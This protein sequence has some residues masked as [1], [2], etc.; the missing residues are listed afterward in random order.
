MRLK[1]LELQGY[2]SFAAKTEFLFF[3]GITAIVG[4]NGSGKSNIADAVRW[5]LG[6]QSYRLLRGKRTED[7][8][9]SGSAQR[10]RAG[11]AQVTMTLDNSSGW[12]PLEYSEISITR[13]AYRSGENE[14]L[15]NGNRVRLRDV[16]ELLGRSGLARRSYTVIGQGLID[17]ALALRPEE[18]RILFEEAAGITIHQM[19]RAEALSKLEATQENL[20]RVK[21]ILSE[22]TPRLQVLQ[23]QAERAEQYATLQDRLRQ[24]LRVWYGHQ[25]FLAE[26]ALHQAQEALRRQAELRDA[27]QQA[28]Q[29]IEEQMD[30]LRQEQ[31]ALREQLGQRHGESARL[32]AE[33]EAL[34]RELAV[35][36][37]RRR[38]M[39][40][41]REALLQ[42]I[43]TLRASA[44]EHQERIAGA[45]E[46]LQALEQE[47]Q[48]QLA[49]AAE[50]EQKVQA[51]QQERQ[52]LGAALSA[53]RDE[54]FQVATR[55]A[56]CRNRMT[57]LDERRQE[58]Q[59]EQRRHQE[60]IAACQEEIG[61]RERELRALRQ[62]LETW[63]EATAVLQNQRQSALEKAEEVRRQRPSIEKRLDEARGQLTRLRARRD[64][65]ARTREEMD[66]F[67][68]GVRSVM[69][70]SIAGV[71][72]PVASHI[73]VPAELERALETALGSHLQDLIVERWEVAEKAIEHLKRVQGGRATFLPLD[74]LRPPAALEVPAEPGVIGLAS[75]LVQYDARLQPAVDLLLNRTLVVE[76]LKTARRVMER[77][78]GSFTIVTRAGE[79]VRSSGSVTGGAGAGER[80]AGMLAREREWRELPGQIAGAEAQVALLTRELEESQRAE[81]RYRQTAQ[82]LERELAERQ[83]QQSSL[84]ARAAELSRQQDRLSQEIE[85][86]QRLI[87]QSRKE[88]EAVAARR[89]QLEQEAGQLAARQQ[90]L[91]EQ[92]QQLEAA[93]AG[94]I[95][96]ELV[97]QLNA[98]RAAL[99]SA[100]SRRDSQLQ[101][102]RNFQSM[103]SQAQQQIESKERRLHELEAQM[104]ELE[105]RRQT[106]DARR[107]ELQ[108]SLA[109]IDAQV[110]PMERR[111]VELERALQALMAEEE[112]RRR[113]LHDAESL[114]AAASLEH[115][116]KEEHVRSLHRQ[117]EEELGLVEL[118]PVEGLAEQAPLPLESLVSALPAVP[119]LPEGLEEEIRQL[120]GQI[121]R[122]GAVNPEAPEE[123]SSLLQRYTFL[124]EQVA[125]LEQA[126]R[127]LRAVISELDE[128]MQADFMQT[129]RAVNAQFKQFF[130]ALFGGGSARLVLTEPDNLSMTGVDI[131]A[132]PPGKRQQS[133]ALLSGGERALTAAALI[134]AILKVSPTPFCF[135]DE[136][137]AMLDE[138]NVGRFREA[139]KSLSG[140]TQFIVITHNRG[141]VEAADTIYGITMGEDGTSRSISLRLEGRDVEPANAA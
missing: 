60:H 22:I 21:D 77:L 134:F 66:G 1:R 7:M 59:E 19:K 6:E 118:E 34:E 33:L 111:L 26:Q 18:R 107:Q 31:A 73:T 112:R 37:E 5:V 25:W 16:M 106:A 83:R 52:R 44:A 84:E 78:R 46:K 23:K 108:V 17:A 3:D 45:Q 109:D 41:Q 125:D 140:Q 12:L 62:E 58:L 121:R 36:E 138:A 99:S 133:L 104:Q 53:A 89:A 10:P 130:S 120:R 50:V 91:E 2:K 67:Y 87:A 92:L 129:F 127:S 86:H 115:Q 117:I 69:Q 9:F 14:Y 28:L 90:A 32:H 61:Q 49:A 103:L 102:L 48:S 98:L 124:S 71:L 29:E 55:L 141:T 110:R 95:D 43:I 128:I 96:D 131:I 40:V 76:D 75:Q 54:A 56:D 122:L 24:L 79:I 101:L 105:D 88:V 116:R 51:L 47:Y 137:D 136:V 132:Q 20:L 139:L 64:V 39:E 81:A 27:R 38:Q 93:R 113:Q 8:I 80:Q 82:D 114:F 30:T 57:Q 68:A 100:A 65:L 15:I 119:E 72:G 135:L 94:I 11:M 42:D 74:T 97:N 70:A 13:R 123:Y 85:W 126:S 63:Q 35:W 4:P